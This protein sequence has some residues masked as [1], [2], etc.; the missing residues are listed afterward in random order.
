MA[1][2]QE[3]KNYWLLKASPVRASHLLAAKFLVAYLP[4]LALGGVIVLGLAVIQNIPPFAALYNL[5][6]LV[7]G[8]IQMAGILVAFGVPG[9]NFA[10]DDPRKMSSGKFGCLGLIVVFTY[11]LVTFGLFV[12]PPLLALF[13]DQPEIYG[14]LIGLFLGSIFSI[15][16][17]L[18]A[19]WL[20]KGGVE[21]LGEAA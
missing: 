3:G 12:G 2:S 18:M 1:F 21:R 8:L 10:W 14:Y 7:F 5:L 4:A 11:S 20:A 16:G 6:I 19:L 17:A 15:G 9:A 13:L